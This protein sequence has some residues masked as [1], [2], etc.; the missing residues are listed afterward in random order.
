MERCMCGDPACHSCGDP[1]Q[2]RLQ[3]MLFFF[4]SKAEPFVA[5][6]EDSIVAVIERLYLENAAIQRVL[7]DTFALETSKTKVPCLECNGTGGCTD[8]DGYGIELC[9]L[10]SGYGI[11][12]PKPK[13]IG[14]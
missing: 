9:R 1:E 13:R 12:I 11:V 14:Q 2:E 4:M 3:E 5:L 8:E 7:Q 10:C 6:D